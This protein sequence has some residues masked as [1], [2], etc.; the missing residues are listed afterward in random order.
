MTALPDDIVVRIGTFCAGT[1]NFRSLVHLSL[2][3]KAVHKGLK[4]VLDHPVL[5]WRK[6]WDA[7]DRF[8]ISNDFLMAKDVKDHPNWDELQPVIAAWSTVK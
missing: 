8:P 6:G 2:S 5:V 4:P 7:N 1:F 3:R